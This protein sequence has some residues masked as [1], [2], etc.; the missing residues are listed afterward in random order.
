MFP[1]APEAH[2]TGGLYQADTCD[3]AAR[4]WPGG[5]LKTAWHWRTVTAGAVPTTAPLLSLACRASPRIRQKITGPTEDPVLRA[6]SGLDRAETVP[7]QIESS[8][9]S[10]CQARPLSRW[11]TRRPNVPPG[12]EASGTRDGAEVLPPSARRTHRDHELTCRYAIGCDS[13]RVSWC[14][15]SQIRA[16]GVQVG[17]RSRNG[18][19][20]LGCVLI[21]LVMMT[22][23]A[24][25][26]RAARC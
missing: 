21:Q 9:S 16:I 2:A 11:V 7:V 13:G 8:R 4:A 6:A 26:S 3:T 25:A 22:G 5:S 18:N 23:S 20:S 17:F 14:S 1:Y 19:D 24:P 10:A 12:R 15:F